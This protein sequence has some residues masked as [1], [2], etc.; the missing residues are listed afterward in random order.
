M[1]LCT[2]EDLSGRVLRAM[3]GNDDLCTSRYMEVGLSGRVLKTVTGN[4]NVFE[5]LC[6]K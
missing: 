1:R 2:E 4:V 5:C 6:G 3:V